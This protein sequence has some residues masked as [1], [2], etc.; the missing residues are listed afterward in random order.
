MDL[1]HFKKYSINSIIR[2]AGDSNALEH[3]LTFFVSVLDALDIHFSNPEN[4]PMR[5]VRD[6]IENKIPV[7][8]LTAKASIWWSIIDD[9]AAMREFR[10]RNILMARLA[11]CLL[12]WDE[13]KCSDLGDNLSWFLELLHALNVDRKIPTEMMMKYFEYR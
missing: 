9:S 6:Y 2:P 5:L 4:D 7:E 11:I 8:T 10:D 12:Y 1:E 3:Q 13:T